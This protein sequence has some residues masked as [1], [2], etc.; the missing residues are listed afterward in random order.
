MAVLVE[1]RLLTMLEQQAVQA[2][3]AA[4]VVEVLVHLVLQQAQTQAVQAAMALYTFTT[5]ELLNNVKI[6]ST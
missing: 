3:Q 5:K 6:C 2:A 1:I 4:A